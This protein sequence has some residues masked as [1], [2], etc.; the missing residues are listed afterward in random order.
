[1]DQNRDW[2]PIAALVLAGLALLVALG[3][4]RGYNSQAMMP[5]QPIIVQPVAPS[6]GGT[7]AP[8]APVITAPTAP[9]QPGHAWGWGGGHMFP[10]FPIIPLLFLAG[11]IFLIFRVLGH[12]RYGWGGPG[13]Y[14]RPWG[15]PGP[16]PQGPSQ[17][18]PYQQYPPQYGQGQAPQ[19]PYG[20]YPQQPAQGQQ[21]QQ[22]QPPHADDTH[23]DITH[24]EGGGY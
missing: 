19:Q 2:K 22:G 23:G 7:G 8:I 9:Q 21:A 5:P 11:F 18:Q 4:A 1:M 14:G 20:N 6:P 12:R 15:G 24:P 10:F 13:G 3:G 17:G 16:G